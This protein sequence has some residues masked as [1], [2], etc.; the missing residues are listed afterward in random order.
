M[1]GKYSE[2]FLLRE[3]I[4]ES[5]N[6]I[7]YCEDDSISLEM[8]LKAIHEILPQHRLIEA[9]SVDEALYKIT[10]SISSLK[11]VITDGFLLGAECGWDLA[12]LLRNINYKG[13]IIYYGNAQIPA[14]KESLFTERFWKGSKS[15]NERKDDFSYIF[16]HYLNNS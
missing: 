15:Y 7:L 11:C 1:S 14:G 10:N 4:P 2:N 13:P 5:M 9:S 16:S 8:G 12:K 6:T 3:R